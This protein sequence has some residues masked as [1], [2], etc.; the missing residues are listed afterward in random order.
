[1]GVL[2]GFQLDTSIE[3]R[4]K[5]S[6]DI[7][8]LK[9][10]DNEQKQQGIITEIEKQTIEV[11]AVILGTQI[12]DPIS[13]AQRLHFIDKNISV[14][15]LCTPENY[16]HMLDA[17]Q[18]AP[19]LGE[20]VSCHLIENI[21]EISEKVKY[22]VANTQRR[23]EY[24]D[25]ITSMNVQI[26]GQNSIQL[27]TARYVDRLLD[28][29]P[30][31]IVL[32]DNNYKVLAWNK[33]A[34]QLFGKPERDVLGT[35]L[36]AFF[37][38]IE[39][40]RFIGFAASSR[41]SATSFKEIFK[42]EKRNRDTQVLEVNATYLNHGTPNHPTLIIFED[43]TAKV[44]E[45]QKRRIAEENLARSE[46]QFRLMVEGARDFAIFML[47]PDGKVMSWN[48]GAKDLLGY[49]ENEVIGKDFSFLFTPEDIKKK[50]A[51][52]EIEAAIKDGRAEDDNWTI[53]KD[54][55]RFFA[56]GVTTTVRDEKGDIIGLVKVFRDVTDRK[57]LEDN[58]AYLAEASKILSSSLD[59]KETL[60]NIA[61]AAVPKIA[62]WCAVE[63]LNA[64]G[65]LEQVT[66]AHKDSAKVKWAKEL[67]KVAPPDMNA[68][69][70]LPN[71][72][73]TGKSELYPVITDDL[74]VRIAKDKKHLKLLRSIGFTSAMIVPLCNEKKCI[75]GITFV[76][77]ET[78][79]NYKQSDL[80]MA[81]ELGNRASLAL[82][83]AGLYKT[84]QDAV[85]LR[86]NFISVAS[87]ELRTPVTSV[88]IF[89]QL[90]HQHSLQIGDEKA[91]KHLSKMDKQLNKLIELIYNL[92]NVSKIQ[93]GRMEFAEKPFDIDASVKEIVSV[94]QEGSKHKIMIDG[95]TNKIVYGDEERIGQVVSNL[96]SNAIKYSPKADKVVIHLS[97]DNNNVTVCIEDFGIG[98]AKEHLDRV[99]ERF[100]RVFDTTDKTFPGLG[101]GLYI[102]SEIVRRHHGKLWVESD[103]GIGSKFYFS[104]PLQ[105]DKKP[106]GVQVL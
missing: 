29:A 7:P 50:K 33:K 56:T 14:I 39:Q 36:L 31:G 59:Y 91:I 21:H 66:V 9:N 11:D 95:G 80:A 30:V 73:R 27:Q 24:Q 22:A 105:R 74:L 42:R 65:K 48:S 97:S 101:I 71:V 12:K 53:K 63:L 46:E 13:I 2:I 77:A 76:N 23:R 45:E 68:H 78:K 81:E 32:V 88:K 75:G 94:L 52:T 1:M 60:S 40:K 8:K 51:K 92:L 49:T 58:L 57:A 85:A 47:T 69:H 103:T 35:S 79:R 17:V 83:N 26:P 10:V 19:F 5:K 54:G 18:F 44:A 61:K 99:F 86:D 15:I 55:S 37:S 28:F 38:Q 3:D 64:G 41:S 98:M 82:E 16:H 20:E 34:E 84:S 102:S 67:R 62:D 106:N 6:Y 93:A 100:Y 25:A 90:L 43:I 4:L 72:M 104:L 70:G 96:I 87:H 89:T